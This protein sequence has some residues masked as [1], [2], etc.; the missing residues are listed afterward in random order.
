MPATGDGGGLLSKGRLLMPTR[1][2]VVAR[3]RLGAFRE[4][5]RR[6][7]ESSRSQG[8]GRASCRRRLA[9]TE[10]W[11]LLCVVNRSW[12]PGKR[13]PQRHGGCVQEGNEGEKEG[14]KASGLHGIVT[15]R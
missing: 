13:G 14:L 3:P 4:Q 8:H 15:S 12:L 6:F 5:S 2:G 10:P 7:P 1:S 11:R 9:Q